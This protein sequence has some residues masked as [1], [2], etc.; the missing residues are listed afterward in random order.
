MPH[1]GF[2]Q[3]LLNFELLF[4]QLEYAVLLVDLVADLAALDLTSIV[5]GWDDGRLDAVALSV[6]LPQPG[7]WGLEL[8]VD[9][10]HRTPSEIDA[11]RD[12]ACSIAAGQMK[13]LTA[14][15]LLRGV[16][17]AALYK[18]LIDLELYKWEVTVIAEQA[19]FRSDVIY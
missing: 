15:G 5:C 18:A 11:L 2:D 12:R 1:V 3:R 6:P 17:C 8:V 10:A 13:D 16:V 4:G 19:P 7:W 9:P 14:H